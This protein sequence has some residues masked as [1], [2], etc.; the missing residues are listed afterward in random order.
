MLFIYQKTSYTFVL[1]VI[2]D[3]LCNVYNTASIE[4]CTSAATVKND[5]SKTVIVVSDVLNDFHNANCRVLICPINEDITVNQE[6]VLNCFWGFHQSMIDPELKVRYI[7][8]NK[9]EEEYMVTDSLDTE[10]LLAAKVV[11]CAENSIWRPYL[12]ANK[13]PIKGLSDPVTEFKQF[14]S[15]K[16]FCIENNL[17]EFNEII[18][19]HI[20]SA[21]YGSG[22]TFIDVTEKVRLIS[23][24]KFMVDNKTMGCDP[25]PMVKKVLNIT[26]ID[27]KTKTYNEGEVVE[28]KQNHLGFIVLRHV[29]SPKSARYWELCV[30]RIKLYHPDAMVVIIDDHSNQALINKELQTN[31]I[32]VNS[33]YPPGKGELLPYLYFLKYE[34]FKTAVIVHDSVFLNTRIVRTTDEAIPLW[35][36]RHDWDNSGLELSIIKKL[37][38]SSVVEKVLHNQKQ[39]DGFFGGMSI[40][41]KTFLQCID[42]KHNLQKLSNH[43]STR[44]ERMA[45]ERVIACI[46]RANQTTNL[47][48]KSVFGDIHD[49]GIWGLPY[50]RREKASHLPVTK[51]WSGR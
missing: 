48:E 29:N 38:N 12:I 33:S 15:K 40:I 18:T 7:Y 28:K 42:R 44:E 41:N 4:K 17:D 37:D 30:K 13:I 32:V 46:C 1:K 50:E 49:Y 2:N 35:H 10:A 27:G 14:S 24:S 16:G 36:F 25:L 31:L 19:F 34:W 21:H 43:I 45:F 3:Y 26:F 51:V 39:W 47:S 23:S 5:A 11:S 6:E 9:S 22:K 8:T 20:Q